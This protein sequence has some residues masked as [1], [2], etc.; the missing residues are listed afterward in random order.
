M[1]C[2]DPRASNCGPGPLKYHV[3]VR[4]GIWAHETGESYYGAHQV[5]EVT[6]R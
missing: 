5:Y 6:F 3:A 2:T 4:A 1:G